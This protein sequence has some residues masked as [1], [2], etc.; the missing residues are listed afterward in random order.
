M[1]KQAELVYD[2]TEIIQLGPSAIMHQ[3]PG[4]FTKAQRLAAARAARMTAGALYAALEYWP[5]E[6]RETPEQ[7]SIC[8]QHIL[9][10]NFED[11]LLGMAAISGIE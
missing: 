8:L 5:E 4:K 10:D 3:Y 6:L 11:K 7:V 2:P 1:P 9:F